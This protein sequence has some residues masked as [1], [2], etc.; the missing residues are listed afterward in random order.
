MGFP[1]G[2]DSKDSACQCRR[3]GSLDWEDSLEKGMA[4]HSSI[5]ARRIPWTEE[6]CGLY[7]PGDHIELDTTEQ[8][9]LSHA[10]IYRIYSYLYMYVYSS[11][12]M[13]L[14]LCVLVLVK[15]TLS[16]SSHDDVSFLLC[17]YFWNCSFCC[18]WFK[19]AST[20]RFPLDSVLKLLW[21]LLSCLLS[22]EMEEVATSHPEI[23]L[24]GQAALTRN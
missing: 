8:L 4:T 24:E 17:K 12:R 3:P 10:F 19:I 15:F 13:S 11:I 6:P 21:S 1:G 7:N 5:L 20:P 9:S 14:G 16:Q 23:V 18:F 22:K 2:S